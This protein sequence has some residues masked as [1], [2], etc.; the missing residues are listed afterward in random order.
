[1]GRRLAYLIGNQ[2]FLL[3]SGLLPL[4]GPHN[5]VAILAHLLSDPAHGCFEVH[6]FFDQPHYAI[7]PAIEEG[8]QTVRSGDLV[9][10]F[11][12]GHGKPDA[13]GKLYLATANTR[14][15][16]LQSTSMPAWGLHEAVQASPC[17][18]V[19]LLLDCCYSGAVSQG[20][21]GALDS[22]L[23][24]VQ[25]AAGFYIL[26]A[27]TSIQTASENEK[28]RNGKIMGRFTAAIVDGIKTGSADLNRK[29]RIHLSDLKQ[30]LER[31]VRG[32]TPQFFAHAGSGDPLISFSPATAIPLL[33]RDALADLDAESWHRRRGA[34]SYLTG[35]LREGEPPARVAA[36]EVLE[37]R[38]SQERDYHVRREIETALASPAKVLPDAGR[39]PAEVALPLHPPKRLWRNWIGR[40]GMIIGTLLTATAVTGLELRPELLRWIKTLSNSQPEA[41][42]I[43]TA[44]TVTS[45]SAPVVPAVP[46]TNDSKSSGIGPL[47]TSNPYRAFI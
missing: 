24:A 26:T 28:E 25:N 5:D 41:L 23:Q 9:L 33:D 22:Q 7:L 6:T 8:L 40:P 29:G 12:S 19:V 18:Q 39:E 11:Y 34:V 4:R 3:E 36:R 32:Q 20:L 27:S 14:Q 15:A 2:S 45:T 44:R 37:Q 13:S 31:T 21:R 16:A 38:L 46:P 17:D 35:V 42:Q 43:E 47:A 30:H 1:M 10:L